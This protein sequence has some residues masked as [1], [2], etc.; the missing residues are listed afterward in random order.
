M[1]KTERDDFQIETKYGRDRDFAG[2]LNW[3]DKPETYESLSKGDLAF[4][5]WASTGIQRV[6]YGYEFRTAPSA[7]ALYLIETF[8]AA[9]NVEDVES[10]IYHYSIKNHGFVNK[11]QNATS[12]Q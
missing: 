8:I 10:G 1:R 7:G 11:R 3:A 6:E 9:N 5:L 4:L 2:N 12:A